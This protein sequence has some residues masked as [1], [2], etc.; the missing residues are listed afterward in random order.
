MMNHFSIVFIS[1]LAVAMAV[2]ASLPAKPHAVNVTETP[3]TVGLCKADFVEFVIKP[4][5]LCFCN[6]LLN[7][8]ISVN[9]QDVVEDDCVAFFGSK[10][11]IL[12]VD[13]PCDDFM[14]ENRWL[15][16]VLVETLIN[17]I[18]KKCFPEFLF[19]VTISKH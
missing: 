5:G 8:V 10:K 17:V 12:D 6:A 18:Y 2:P 4:A 14:T 16:I 11:A 15:N 7:D 3:E 9:S 13:E 1:L 19:M